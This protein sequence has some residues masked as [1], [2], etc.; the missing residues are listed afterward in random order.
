MRKVVQE[1]EAKLKSSTIRIRTKA[2]TSKNSVVRII[3]IVKQKRR[4]KA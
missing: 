3:C 2:T 4:A 1:I